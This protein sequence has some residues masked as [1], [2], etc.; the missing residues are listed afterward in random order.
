MM[1]CFL[2]LQARVL[3]F[4]DGLMPQQQMRLSFSEVSPSKMEQVLLLATPVVEEPG[5]KSPSQGG[6]RLT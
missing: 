2:G 5:P 6:G 1:T 4:V 3:D